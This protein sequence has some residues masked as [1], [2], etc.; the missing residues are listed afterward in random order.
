VASHLRSS[1][2]G[3]HTTLPEH[4]PKAHAAHAEWTPQRLVCWASE[5]GPATAALVEAILTTRRHPV[6]KAF[7]PA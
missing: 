5:C 6:A 3:W 4:M 7:V 1:A 2:R